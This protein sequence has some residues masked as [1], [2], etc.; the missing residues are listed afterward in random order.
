MRNLHWIIIPQRSHTLTCHVVAKARSVTI[1]PSVPARFGQI[2]W[3]GV[4]LADFP[5]PVTETEKMFFRLNTFAFVTRATPRVAS[6]L[7][8]PRDSLVFSFAS[9]LRQRRI[10]ID[11][12]LLIDMSP[13]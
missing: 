7:A 3:D 9:E 4:E 6:S 2:G 12:N 8:S 10:P 13:R 1:V 5:D 11:L